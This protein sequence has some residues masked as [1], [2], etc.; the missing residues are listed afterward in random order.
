MVILVTV[1]LLLLLASCAS[2]AATRTDQSTSASQAAASNAPAAAATSTAAADPAAPPRRAKS[3]RSDPAADAKAFAEAIKRGDK[4]WQAGEVDRAVYYYVLALEHSPQD[5]PTLAKIG[6][7]KQQLGQTVLAEKAFE[8][9]H[10][11]QPDEPRIAERLAQ[12]YLQQDKVDAAAR[13]Y[14]EV[15]EQYP[16]RSRAL[17]GMGDV[18]VLRGE[19]PQA[20]DYF[21]RALQADQ[22]DAASILTHRGY[23]KLRVLDLAGAESD[24]RAALATSS[25]ADAWR[26]LADLQVRQHDNAGAYSSLTKVMDSAHAYNE[27]GLVLLNMNSFGDSY[28]YFTKA[29]SASAT[30]Y[31]EAQRNL[32]LAEEHLHQSA[33]A[34]SAPMT[35]R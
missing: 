33:D 30:W 20:I 16:Q 35:A 21:D 11:A 13:I 25:R 8:L 12:L 22:P 31:D 23:A 9:A 7:I 3:V 34:G 29:I 6:A 4:A 18:C 10:S 19:F 27:I 24:L 32:E 2:S 26:Y 28:S 15:L 5:A 1:P 14:G 17:D